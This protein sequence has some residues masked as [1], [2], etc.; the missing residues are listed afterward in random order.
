MQ[1]APAR[2]PELWRIN[3]HPEQG[4]INIEL[5]KTAGFNV[6]YTGLINTDS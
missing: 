3:P 5:D 6:N 1:G 2:S 4:L